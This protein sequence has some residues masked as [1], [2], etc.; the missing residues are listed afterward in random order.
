ML[1]V[2]SPIPGAATESAGAPFSAVSKQKR[3]RTWDSE[4]DSFLS[5]C[6]SGASQGLK[7]GLFPARRGLESW[8]ESLYCADFHIL[9]ACPFQEFMCCSHAFLSPSLIHTPP[10]APILCPPPGPPASANAI[11]A[12][13][14]GGQLRL[15]PPIV[16]WLI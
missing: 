5:F 1:Q 11:S 10:S 12:A 15:S 8:R 14:R 16:W 4:L 13:L 6:G 7:K 9:L 3:Q 2:G